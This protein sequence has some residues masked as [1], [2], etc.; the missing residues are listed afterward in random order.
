MYTDTPT[1]L[2]S[3]LTGSVY[4]KGKAGVVWLIKYYLRFPQ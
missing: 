4:I 3:S 1:M 2:S